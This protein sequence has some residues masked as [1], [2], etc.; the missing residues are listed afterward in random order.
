MKQIIGGF[1]KNKVL[2]LYVIIFATINII[3]LYLGI[4]KSQYIQK[5][6]LLEGTLGVDQFQYLAQISKVTSFLEVLIILVYLAYMLKVLF[7]KDILNIKQ[8]VGMNF[9]LVTCLIILNGV[10]SFAFSA[11]VGNLIQQLFIPSQT[12]FMVLICLIGIEIYKKI[13]KSFRATE[14]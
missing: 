9:I 7:K 4:L 12:T 10:V 2:K 13:R 1:K 8:L 11:P 5:H 3:Y 14:S 6:Q